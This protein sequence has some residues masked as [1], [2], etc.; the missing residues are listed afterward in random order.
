MRIVVLKGAP[1][2]H[3][4]VNLEECNAYLHRSQEDLA[5]FKDPLRRSFKSWKPG[6]RRCETA[7][8]PLRHM[9]AKDEKMQRKL[10]EE[11]KKAPCGLLQR[12]G[13]LGIDD[14]HLETHFVR[15][16]HNTDICMYIY[17]YM[18]TPSKRVSYRW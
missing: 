13:E 6:L 7:S 16:Y 17:I 12:P 2:L 18:G 4:H 15:S 10:E 5:D 11:A 8:V 1:P 14:P 9:L 3:F